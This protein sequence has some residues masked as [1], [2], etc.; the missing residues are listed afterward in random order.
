VTSKYE[1]KDKS[2]LVKNL[3]GSKSKPSIFSAG[4]NPFAQKKSKFSKTLIATPSKFELK[5]NRPSSGRR[6]SSVK[7]KMPA[8]P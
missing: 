7:S 2:S 4:N 5:V 8:T 3:F 1:K 6:A